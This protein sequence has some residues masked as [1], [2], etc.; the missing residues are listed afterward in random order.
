[1]NFLILQ[2]FVQTVNHTEPPVG[3]ELFHDSELKR[4]TT[5]LL[6]SVLQENPIMVL[7]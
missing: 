4:S 6:G 2:Y 5:P 7:R 3:R 1:M